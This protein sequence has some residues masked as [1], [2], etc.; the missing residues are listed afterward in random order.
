M[1][2]LWMTFQSYFASSRLRGSLLDRRFKSHG[3][4]VVTI[5]LRG[6]RIHANRRSCAPPLSGG[7]LRGAGNWMDERLTSPFAFVLM[8]CGAALLNNLSSSFTRLRGFG[9]GLQ[10]F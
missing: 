5:R 7:V 3:G 6:P 9:A 10:L 8:R 4:A 2:R 1:Q